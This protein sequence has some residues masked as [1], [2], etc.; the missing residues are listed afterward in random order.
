MGDA[1]AG[2]LF[3]VGPSGS[4]CIDGTSSPGMTGSWSSLSRHGLG[5]AVMRR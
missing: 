4:S 2:F 1:V 5:V 3:G